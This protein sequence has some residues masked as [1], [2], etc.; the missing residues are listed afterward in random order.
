VIDSD[1]KDL[2]E[3]LIEN[4]LARICGTKA[5]LPDGRNSKTYID[6]LKEIAAKAKI[7]KKGAWR[8]TITS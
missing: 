6:H 4:G 2:N 3:S 7:D 8:F 5:P 1:G